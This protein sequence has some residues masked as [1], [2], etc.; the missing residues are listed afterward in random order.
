MRR[1]RVR[2][3]ACHVGHLLE[4]VAREVEGFQQ[5]EP[6]ERARGPQPR[7]ERIPRERERAQARPRTTIVGADRLLVL[8]L[9]SDAAPRVEAS[10]TD[11][12]QVEQ[13]QR[14]QSQQPRVER[15]AHGCR[16]QSLEGLCTGAQIV[17]LGPAGTFTHINFAS[18]I[19]T[20]AA[21]MKHCNHQDLSH[22]LGRPPKKSPK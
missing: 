22:S 13:R 18:E 2:A 16:L 6:E 4:A 15:L 9:L 3:E 12:A 5:R 17:A 10:Q 19:D 7:T 14:G 11:A 1:V 20:T 8:L 21:S